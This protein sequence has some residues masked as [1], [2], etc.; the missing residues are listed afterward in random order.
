MP[1]YPAL[2][3]TGV[4][5]EAQGGGLPGNFLPFISEVISISRNTALCIL[6]QW[7]RTIAS[8]FICLVDFSQK[9]T[10]QNCIISHLSPSTFICTH[11]HNTTSPNQNHL[12][13]LHEQRSQYF[14][15]NIFFSHR[16]DKKYHL[17]SKPPQPSV[18]ARNRAIQAH[19]SACK[20]CKVSVGSSFLPFLCLP[21]HPWL[22]T[23]VPIQ[24][25]A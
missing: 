5:L 14:W 7:T 6:L 23:Q 13:I 15:E 18:T 19:T 21:P 17:P 9:T 20:N 16:K 10:K 4:A 11:Q 8:L 12:H 24:T 2:Q 22:R 1:S 3:V 25:L